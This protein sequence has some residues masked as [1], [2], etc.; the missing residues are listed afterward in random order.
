MKKSK[1]F[2]VSN[3]VNNLLDN[4]DKKF[5]NGNIQSINNNTFIL[6]NFFLI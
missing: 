6:I 1:K 2:G 3:Y 4:K 5:E